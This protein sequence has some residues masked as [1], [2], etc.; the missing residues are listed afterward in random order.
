MPVSGGYEE[1]L[2][3]AKEALFRRGMRVGRAVEDRGGRFF[4][5]EGAVISDRELLVKAWG[6]ALAEEILA[7]YGASHEPCEKCERL[8]SEYTA[9]TPE[10]LKLYKDNLMAERGADPAE[11]A[12]IVPMLRRVS[13][14]RR[15]ARL[16]LMKHG[17]SLH[18]K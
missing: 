12:R 13:E 14:S 18:A 16:S 11:L 5:L 17:R 7:E 2:I 4:R 3:H 6:Y 1:A 8:W 9:T 10:Y 15:A